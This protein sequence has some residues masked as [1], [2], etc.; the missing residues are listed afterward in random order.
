MTL[1]RGALSLALRAE[2]Q[3]ISAA[4]LDALRADRMTS[5]FMAVVCVPPNLGARPR[6]PHTQ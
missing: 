2:Q 6:Y 5:L 4:M 3:P 1:N